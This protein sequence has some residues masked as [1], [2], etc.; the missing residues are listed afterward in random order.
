MKYLSSKPFTGGANSKAF[1]D[2]W[3]E[4]FGKKGSGSIF[5]SPW[6]GAMEKGSPC[7]LPSEHEG[8]H[9]TQKDKAEFQAGKSRREDERLDFLV[10][11]DVKAR[12]TLGDPQPCDGNEEVSAAKDRTPFTELDRQV[13][14]SGLER[15][16][17]QAYLDRLFLTLTGEEIF[18]LLLLLQD[19]KN[20]APKTHDHL[21]LLETRSPVPLQM[22]IDAVSM[23]EEFFRRLFMPWVRKAE[24]AWRDIEMR[25]RV[26]ANETQ[27]GQALTVEQFLGL[28]PLVNLSGKPRPKFQ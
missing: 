23:F 14:M 12:A 25:G 5:T 1:V 15:R 6:C 26:P 28:F 24:S 27:A 17:K 18:S 11:W 20:P 22:R 8:K 7:I 10:D 13:A 9:Y 21:F 16:L 19:L 3:A 2:H 4:S